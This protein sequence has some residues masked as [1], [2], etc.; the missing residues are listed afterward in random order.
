MNI[1]AN[2][3]EEDKTQINGGITIN[4]VAT[5]KNITYV[6]EIV[7][8]IL[9]HVAVKTVNIYQIFLMKQRLFVMNL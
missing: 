8:R 9:P 6:K 3:M 7:L 5:V 1:N 2:L 4:V